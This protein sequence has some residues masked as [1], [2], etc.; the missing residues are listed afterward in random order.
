[1]NA[2]PM[3]EKLGLSGDDRVVIIHTDDIGMC[4][5]S[6]QAFVDLWEYGLISSGSTMVPSSW[7]PQVA[8]ICSENIKVDMGVHLTLTSEWDTYRWSPISTC[9]KESGLIDDDGYFFHR[10]ED[11]QEHGDPEAAHEELQAQIERARAAGINITHIDTHML[12]VAHPKFIQG[13]I[14]LA[15]KYKIP[16]LFPRQDEAGFMTLGISQELSEI[17]VNLVRTLESQG[18]PLVDNVAGLYLD[19]PYN[20]LE[21]AM[22]AMSDLPA[23]ITHFVIH[24]SSNTDELKAITPDWQSRVA[25]YQTFMDDK[26]RAHIKNI[27]IHVIGYRTLKELFTK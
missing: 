22:Q 9:R 17:A 24:P 27:G 14:Q 5:A 20:R 2:N 8:K 25:D 7:F 23:G 6:I 18:I 3:L 21:Q 19:K 4:R 15:I 11:A 16:F 1:M 12:A 26:L 10:S 13:Y